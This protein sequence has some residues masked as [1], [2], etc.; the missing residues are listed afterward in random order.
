MGRFMLCVPVCKY[1]VPFLKRFSCRGKLMGIHLAVISQ[2][3]TLEFLYPT[4]FNISALS[5]KG[6]VS[7][8]SFSCPPWPGPAQ[9]VSQRWLRAWW[10]WAHRLS[11]GWHLCHRAR[12]RWVGSLVAW[13][14]FDQSRDDYGW[15]AKKWVKVMSGW[16]FLDCREIQEMILSLRLCLNDISSW[17]FVY[18]THVI[19]KLPSGMRERQILRSSM[20]FWRAFPTCK[21]R[22]KVPILSI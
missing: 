19:V 6:N 21:C 1:P 18:P 20:R 9:R 13:R 12:R 17:G 10:L 16:M 15:L 2:Q 11:L 8:S 7:F 22:W 3:L 5:S 14:Y 4:H